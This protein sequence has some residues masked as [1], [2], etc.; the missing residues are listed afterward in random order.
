MAWQALKNALGLSDG[1]GVRGAL[2]T[3]RGSFGYSASGAASAGSS[4]AFTIAVVALS[5]KMSKA[6]GV[7][8]DVEAHVFEQ[9]FSVPPED[10]DNVR[11]LYALASQD[12]AG[13]EAYAAQISRL[14]TDEPDLKLS[15]LECLFHIASA[16]GVLHPAEDSY[17]TNVAGILGVSDCEFRCMRRAFVIDPDSPYEILD[18]SPDATMDEIKAR[19]RDLVKSHHPDLLVSKGVPPELL[20]AAERRLAAITT[21][22]EA[23]QRERG[24]RANRA[25]EPSAL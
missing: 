19:Y 3:L 21:S 24:A 20:A 22:F 2:D 16:D 18:V 13:F 1:G 11:R 10:L 15:V 25:L 17:L 23:I 6:D 5:A 7:A 9:Q 4:V 12:V 14:L 8:S